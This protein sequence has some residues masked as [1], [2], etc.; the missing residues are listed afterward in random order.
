[1]IQEMAA[2]QPLPWNLRPDQLCA[3]NRS[4]L[5][6]RFETLRQQVAGPLSVREVRQADSEGTP[7]GTQAFK[8][9]GSYPTRDG[10]VESAKTKVV[11][12]GGRFYVTAL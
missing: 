4:E 8:V 12:R 2:G 1:M 5:R 10:R 6:S 3:L 7:R 9:Y 11:W